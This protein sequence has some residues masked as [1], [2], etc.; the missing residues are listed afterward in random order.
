MTRLIEE[1]EVGCAK[2]WRYIVQRSESGS[3][4]WLIRRRMSGEDYG[5]RWE[6][7]GALEIEKEAEAL[8]CWYIA[9][10]SLR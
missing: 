1:K 7:L 6:V 9:R 3:L 8:A 10:S 5:S 4:F 2:G